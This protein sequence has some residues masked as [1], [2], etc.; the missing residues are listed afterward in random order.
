[1]GLNESKLS[2]DE[3]N[4]DLIKANCEIPEFSLNGT[5][6]FGKVVYV[7]DGDTVHIVFKVNNKL[8][9][10]NCRLLGIDSPEIAPK[11][12][13]DEKLRKMEVQSAYKSRN[14]LIS[15]VT[16]KKIE[17]ENMNKNDVKD[18]C[19]KS[20]KLVYV[21]CYDFDKYGRSLVELFDSEESTKAYNLEM[22]EQKYAL[23]YYGD[24]K[25]EFNQSNF[26]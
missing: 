19:S 15:R 9:K 1:M 23:P 20:T 21:K 18:F 8:I 25:K 5:C 6:L 2:N 16:D 7:Y 11:N 3:S 10:L 13:S 17:N 24:T 14:Y 12:I 4:N 26:M 22:V